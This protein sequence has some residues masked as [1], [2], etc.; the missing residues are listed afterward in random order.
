MGKIIETLKSLDRYSNSLII[1]HSD[2]GYHRAEA[3]EPTPSFAPSEEALQE[4]NSEMPYFSA[5]GYFRRIHPM[6]VLKPRAADTTALRYSSAPAQLIDIPASIYDLL[7]ITAP[8]TD[9]ESVFRLDESVPREIHLYSG[10]YKK[11]STQKTLI[12]GHS[13][14]ETDLVHISYTEGRGWKVYPKL[15]GYSD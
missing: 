10:V 3:G 9:G 13:I 6:L 7:G 12:L 11:D 8:K 4:F 14:H 2:H 15:R 1:F 5:D